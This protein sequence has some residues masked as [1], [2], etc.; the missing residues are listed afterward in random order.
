VPY[1]GR[2]AKTAG[3]SPRR[4]PGGLDTVALVVGV[5]LL[6]LTC[7]LS[8]KQFGVRYVLPVYPAAVILG[9]SALH[10]ALAT[11]PWVL[12]VSLAVLVG[13]QAWSAVG[14]APRHLSYFN[15]LAGGPD[16]GPELL[17]N[18]DVDWGQGLRDLQTFLE[19]HGE[20]AVL[21]RTFGAGRPGANGFADR[22]LADPPQCRFV[23]VGYSRLR[24]DLR[25]T[26]ELVPFAGLR[27]S[28]VVGYSIYVYDTTDPAVREAVRAAVRAR[29]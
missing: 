5:G 25:H 20:T 10:R 13:W 19:A 27:P 8:A 6:F 23:A 12:A 24:R 4:S 16:G 28:A 2:G 17:G 26:P 7:S 15:S 22:P 11:R 21:N 18:S 1:P 9:V 29:P 14:I 3:P